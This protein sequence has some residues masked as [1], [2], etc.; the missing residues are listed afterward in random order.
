MN[1]FAMLF[2]M[3][4]QTTKT[5]DK[6]EALV[7]YFNKASDRDKLWAIAILSHRRPRR[8]VSASLL[9]AWASDLSGLP[10]W[11]FEES[12]HVVGDLAETIT[13]VLPPSSE[14]SDETL[15]YWIEF[16]R[17]LEPLDVEAKKYRIF[18]AW[19]RLE[20][21][22]RFVFNKLITGSFRVGVSQSLMVNLPEKSFR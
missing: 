15:T 14:K 3:L 19:L 8:T 22:E 10:S 16:I 13:L 9:G 17:A 4:D 5:L 21:T 1:E 6:I 18:E 7:E 11:L 20:P 12:Y 2:T